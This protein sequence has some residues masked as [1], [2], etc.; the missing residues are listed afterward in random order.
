MAAKK[1]I[2]GAC[3]YCGQMYLLS[4]EDME[5]YKEKIELSDDPEK[6]YNHIATMHCKCLDAK[7][8]QHKEEIGEKARGNIDFLFS[9]DFPEVASFLKGAVD[10]MQEGQM[11]SLSVKIGKKTTAQV[12]RKESGDIYVKKEFKEK[13]EA[14]T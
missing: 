1:S 11:V 8:V 14:E 9:K 6:I 12:K 2:R 10:L 7:V 4:D 3:I 13:E 5:R